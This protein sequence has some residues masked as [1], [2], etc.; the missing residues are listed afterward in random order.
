[1][2]LADDEELVRD[3]FFNYVFEP[4]VESWPR[5]L[6]V[7]NI[8]G[9]MF[10]KSRICPGAGVNALG[11]TPPSGSGLFFAIV[12]VEEMT[13]VED[14]DGLGGGALFGLIALACMVCCCGCCAVSIWKKKKSQRKSEETPQT[15]DEQDA[16]VVVYGASADP[17][18]QVVMTQVVQ[19]TPVP[20]VDGTSKPAPQ[21]GNPNME[22]RNRA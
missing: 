14:E 2:K 20:G 17:M 12:P 18:G 15:D 19:G 4:V 5:Y 7:Y 8:T 1:M 3:D 16:S 9:Q 11:W 10:D 21:E 22:F 13:W 6:T